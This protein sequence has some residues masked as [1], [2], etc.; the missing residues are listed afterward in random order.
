METL[1]S[2][3]TQ[4]LSHHQAIGHSPATIR[5]YRDSLNLLARC[6]AD[7]GIDAVATGCGGHY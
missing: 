5:H 2:L 4:F 3:I 7:L 6:F 1:D